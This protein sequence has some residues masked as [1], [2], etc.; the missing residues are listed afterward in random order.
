MPV[1]SHGIQS[2]QIRAGVGSMGAVLGVRGRLTSIWSANTREHLF[3]SDRGRREETHQTHQ[4][5]DKYSNKLIF[6]QV[7]LQRSV[8]D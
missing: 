8:R 5:F 2:R 1:P 3:S 7:S 4:V 6:I